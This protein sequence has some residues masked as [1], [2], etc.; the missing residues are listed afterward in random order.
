MRNGLE[1]SEPK[2]MF[3]PL[4]ILYVTA[5]NKKKSA[6][7]DKNS[8]TYLCPVYKVNFYNNFFSIQE[9]QISI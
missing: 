2:K 1:E 6:D 5:I 3:A 9:E 8:N 7:G 4:P